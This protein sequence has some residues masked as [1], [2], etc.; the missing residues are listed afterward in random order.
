MMTRTVLALLLLLGA[1]LTSLRA[2]TAESKPT[3]AADTAAVDL[4]SVL[5][6]MKEMNAQLADMARQLDSISKFLGDRQSTSFDTVDRRLRDMER[7][8]DD[9]KREVERLR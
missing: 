4:A 7:A 2:Q 9:L 3:P 6:Q 1:P 8:L 5:K